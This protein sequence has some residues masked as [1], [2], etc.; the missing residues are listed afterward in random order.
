MKVQFNVIDKSIWS[1]LCHIF[2]TMAVYCQP[3]Y[4]TYMQSTAF[5]MLYSAYKLNKQGNSIMSSIIL[6]SK[7]LIHY[8]ALSLL[9]LIA[10]SSA[11]VSANEISNLS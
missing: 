1:F 9:L 2:K 5:L 4:L 6:Y 8:S 3:A 11:F 10:F 7:S